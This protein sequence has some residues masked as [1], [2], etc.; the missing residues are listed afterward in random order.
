M[1]SFFTTIYIAPV[2]DT[3]QRWFRSQHG[4]KVS[5]GVKCIHTYILHLSIL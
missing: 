1:Y 2:R 3:T 5:T 4:Q